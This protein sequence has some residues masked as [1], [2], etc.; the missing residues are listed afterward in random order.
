M[1]SEVTDYYD[2]RSGQRASVGARMA[3]ESEE[4]I[5]SKNCYRYPKGFQFTNKDL[6][7][8]KINFRNVK[9][10][11]CGIMYLAKPK[12][13]KYSAEWAL[14]EIENHLP[15]EGTNYCECSAD[16]VYYI[17]QIRRELRRKK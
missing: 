16:L 12:P 14:Q 3:C 7:D 1:V 13:K 9:K 17:A 8:A 4:I 6:R 11:K 10:D 15:F 5:M 2:G